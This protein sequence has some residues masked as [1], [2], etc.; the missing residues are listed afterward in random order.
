LRSEKLKNLLLAIALALAVTSTANAIDKIAE[1]TANILYF[2]EACPQG[3]KLNPK[4]LASARRSANKPNVRAAIANVKADIK[5]GASFSGTPRTVP[6]DSNTA[7]KEWC[8][9]EAGVILDLKP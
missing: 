8:D 1:A 6:V 3:K 7:L 4:V 9:V 5:R 2:A